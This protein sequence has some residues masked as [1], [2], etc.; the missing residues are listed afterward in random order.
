MRPKFKADESVTGAAGSGR[1]GMRGYIV[2]AA[3]DPGEYFVQWFPLDSDV[4]TR[5]ADELV[6][7]EK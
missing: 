1:E 7:T 4:E 2:G 6:S 3:Y 5:R